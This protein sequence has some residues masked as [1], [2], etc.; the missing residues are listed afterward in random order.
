MRRFVLPIGLILLALVLR[1]PGLDRWPPPLHQDEASNIV[2]AWSLLDDGMDRAGRVWPVFLQGFGEGD[3]RTSLYAILSIPGIALFGP[4]AVASRLPAALCGAWTVLAVFLFVRRIRGTPAGACAAVLLALNPWH[5]YLSR[6]GHEASL[7]PCFLVTALWLIAEDDSARHPLTKRSCFRWALAGLVL[8]AGLYSYSSFRL[9]LPLLAAGTLIARAGPRIGRRGLIMAAVIALGAL[10]LLVASLAQP[11]RLFA[12]VSVVSVLGNVEPLGAALLLI[13]KQY[14]AHFSPVFLFMRGD[15]NPLQSPPG[16]ELLWAEL[17]C[18]AFGLAILLRRRDRWDRLLLVWLL[19]YPAASAPALGDMPEYVP[20]SL[21]AA[22]G[23]PVF[24]ILGGIGLAAGVG[25]IAGSKRAAARGIVPLYGTG[26]LANFVL[27]AVA[28]TGGYARSVAPRYHAL[29]PAAMTY[30]AENRN[31]YDAALTSCSDNTQAY[32][33]A[34]LHGPITPRDY[35]LGGKEIDESFAFHLV[36]RVE[37]FYFIHDAEDVRRF[38]A[39]VRGRVWVLA[40]VIETSGG[41]VVKTFTYPDGSP[42][43]EI[44][45]FVITGQQGR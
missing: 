2:D 36:R 1:L 20:H 38:N 41:R 13:A 33:Y 40:P 32:I 21:R 45:E 42:G 15:G 17:P 9:F 34:I 23:L 7:T 16:G 28:F 14:L 6:F 11:L 39:S 12:R 43:L 29:H 31:L 26:L 10:P 22:V 25:R 44:R 30:L 37:N 3:N 18:I 19:L 8:A 27:V 5:L 4:G 35:R 24:Q